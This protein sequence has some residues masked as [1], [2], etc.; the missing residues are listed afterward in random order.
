[1][2]NDF[3]D[4]LISTTA[5]GALVLPGCATRVEEGVA[6]AASAQS[7]SGSFTAFRY[8]E[9]VALYVRANAE[10]GLQLGIVSPSVG[11]C[12]AKTDTRAFVE[13]FSHVFSRDFSGNELQQTDEFLRTPVGQKY[14]ARAIHQDL[15]VP[16]PPPT[17][18]I[19]EQRE[20]DEFVRTGV[21]KKLMEW[22]VTR[23]GGDGWGVLV[24]K[25]NEVT[26]NC[27]PAH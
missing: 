27:T 25:L 16:G 21:G 3:R 20:V 14:A 2:G 26:A 13:V 6:T 8:S 18:S 5:L 15:Q 24:A 17:L 23:T 19:T 10:R 11:N 12:L 7:E 1:M 4:L 22:R 9:A